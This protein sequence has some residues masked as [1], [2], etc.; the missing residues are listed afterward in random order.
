VEQIL[1][2]MADAAKLAAV[3][4]KTIQRLAL[5][6]SIPTIKIGRSRR[7]VYAGLVDYIARMQSAA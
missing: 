6:G 3:S 2:T 5:A 7:V 1:L 4:T